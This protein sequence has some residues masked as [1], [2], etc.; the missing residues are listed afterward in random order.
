M[1]DDTIQADVH[2]ENLRSLFETFDSDRDGKISSSEVVLAL[3][4]HHKS[5]SEDEIGYM[6]RFFDLDKDDVVDFG[7]FI[8]MA[9][10][11]ETNRKMTNDIQIRQLFRAAD[12]NKDGMLSPEELKELWSLVQS[13]ENTK[14]LSEN[15]MDDMIR[16]I[17]V[18]GDGKIDFKEFFDLL[19]S[20][21]DA[22]GVL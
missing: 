6:M 12:K 10:L 20:S 17:D 19:S 9:K 8:K 18:N 13:D 1:S 3:Q 21:L 4:N 15:E 2:Y 22:H 5:L 7:E 16:S 14:R 11:F